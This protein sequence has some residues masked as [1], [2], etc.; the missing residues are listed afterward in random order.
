MA[1]ENLKFGKTEWYIIVI[2][3]VCGIIIGIL[4]SCIASYSRRKW[5]TR[6]VRTLEAQKTVSDSTYEELDLTKMDKEDNYQSLS[7]NAARNDG[8]KNNESNY[9]ELNKTRDDENN[10]QSLTS[11]K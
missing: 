11:K 10:Y 4:L 2:S 5:F 3:S 9:T 1:S 6:P 7:E 8:V